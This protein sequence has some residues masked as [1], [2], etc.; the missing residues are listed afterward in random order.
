MEDSPH[1]CN[2]G[3]TLENSILDQLSGNNREENAPD[4]KQTPALIFIFLKC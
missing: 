4:Y 1:R 2:L 3:G